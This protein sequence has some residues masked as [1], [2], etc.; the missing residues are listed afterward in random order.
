[1]RPRFNRGPV[2]QFQTT[3]GKPSLSTPVCGQARMAARQDA[4]HTLHWS[5]RFLKP[6]GIPL[7]V[8]GA[9]TGAPGWSRD[10]RTRPVS[11]PGCPFG[12]SRTRAARIPTYGVGGG[13]RRSGGRF[14]RPPYASRRFARYRCRWLDPCASMDGLGGSKTTS[15]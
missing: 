4:A 12:E 11:I 9:S 10:C 14:H 13:S 1:M 3:Q 6:S 8:H 5:A 2:S 7:P 15:A